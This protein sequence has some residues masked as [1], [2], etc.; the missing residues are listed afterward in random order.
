[1]AQALSSTAASDPSP[2]VR[3]I[4][5]KSGRFYYLNMKLKTTQWQ[6]GHCI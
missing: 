4:D 3:K 1:V 6:V 5:A 2:W